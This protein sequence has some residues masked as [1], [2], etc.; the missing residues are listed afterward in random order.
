MP[1]FTEI[2]GMENQTNDPAAVIS[3]LEQMI[4]GVNKEILDIS[5]TGSFEHNAEGL[6]NF[7]SRLR[8]LSHRLSDLIAAKKLQQVL[9]SAD[10]AKAGNALAKSMPQKFKNYGSRLTRIRMSNG[11]EVEVLAPY[12]ARPCEKGVGKKKR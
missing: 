12:F 9:S 1:I 6:Y 11:T 10:F 5:D 3:H 2:L 8:E 7:E 4:R